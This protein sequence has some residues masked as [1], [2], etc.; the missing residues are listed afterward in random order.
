MNQVKQQVLKE[1]KTAVGVGYTPSVDDLGVPPDSSLGDIA[2]G[3]FA[4]AKQLK[5]NPAEIAVEIA[6]KIGPKELI[7]DVRAVGPYVN[8]VVSKAFQQV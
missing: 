1:L 8:F 3:C 7:H 5:R 4:L 6:A 2:F